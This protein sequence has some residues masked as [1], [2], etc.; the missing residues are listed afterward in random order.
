LKVTLM[1]KSKLVIAFVIYFFF[2]K[3]LLKFFKH[4]DFFILFTRSSLT[5]KKIKISYIKNNCKF[6]RRFWWARES[7]QTW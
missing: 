3:Y 1:I 6:D 2:L 7:G 5:H 4:G